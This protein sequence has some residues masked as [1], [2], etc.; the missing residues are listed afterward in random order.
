MKNSKEYA[1][2]L[3]RFYRSS[4]RKHGKVKKAV[5]DEPLDAMVYGIVSEDMSQAGAQSALHRF[6]DHFVDLNDLRV[7]I[8]GRRIKLLHHVIEDGVAH[9]IMMEDGTEDV[10]PRPFMRPVFDNWQKK[11]EDEAKDGL[12]PAN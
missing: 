1:G 7:S 3:Q 12:V 4:K 5:Y 6:E 11:S 2:K 10:A 9:G 8:K